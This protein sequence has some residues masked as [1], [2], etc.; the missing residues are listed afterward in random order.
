IQSASRRLPNAAAGYG[1]G[2]RRCPAA[3]T[4]RHK[5]CWTVM[6]GGPLVPDRWKTRKGGGEMADMRAIAKGVLAAVPERDGQIISTQPEFERLTG[7][8]HATMKKNWDG[9]GIM[10][11]CN[12][13][14]GWYGRTLRGM[15]PDT[16]APTAYLGRFDLET[17][18]PT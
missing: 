4:I 9:G 7:T 1:R 14:V 8:S 2:R 6:R 16:A 15:V 18:L 11:A 10:T 13:F 12:G 5:A 3:A 17:Y